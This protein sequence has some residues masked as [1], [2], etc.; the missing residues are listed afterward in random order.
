MVCMGMRDHRLGYRPPGVDIN[1]GRRAVQP[2]IGEFK[3][4]QRL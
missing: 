2:K 4:V 3:E 1:I